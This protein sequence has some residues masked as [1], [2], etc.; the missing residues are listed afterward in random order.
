M[1]R[2]KNM[3]EAFKGTAM[4]FIKCIITLTLKTKTKP[5]WQ[6]KGFFPLQLTG[7]SYQ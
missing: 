4:G 5:L 1:D 3:Q 6:L 2:G 7:P